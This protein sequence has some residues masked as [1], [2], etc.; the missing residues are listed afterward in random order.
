MAGGNAFDLSAI[1]SSATGQVFQAFERGSG[2]DEMKD[3]IDA[4]KK[5]LHEKKAPIKNMSK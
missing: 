5:E 1:W 4:A 2:S 3:L